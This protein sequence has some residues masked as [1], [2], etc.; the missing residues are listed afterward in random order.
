MA[1]SAPNMSRSRLQELAHERIADAQALLAA[2]RW[3][4][5][6]YLAGYAVECALKAC[7]LMHVE[8]TGIIFVEKE[9]SKSCFQHDFWS[10]VKVAGLDDDLKRR[11]KASP[12]FAANWSKACEWVSS[13]RYSEWNETQARILISA[14]TDPTSGA[15]AW[16]R[17][18][19]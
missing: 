9:F 16:T 1:T 3:S 14:I 7:I 12:E 18:D 8:R 5:A 19:S 2:G 17:Q 15:L 4:A 11:L 6:Y 13:S 10:L